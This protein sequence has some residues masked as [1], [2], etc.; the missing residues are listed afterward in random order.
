MKKITIKSYALSLVF[1]I[2]CVC[3]AQS[4]SFQFKEMIVNQKDY[5]IFTGDPKEQYA[6][7]M[8]ILKEIIRRENLYYQKYKKYTRTFKELNIKFEDIE[9]RESIGGTNEVCLNSGYCYSISG[10]K[11]GCEKLLVSR[12]SSKKFT[13][14][15]LDIIRKAKAN[16]EKDQKIEEYKNR[17]KSSIYFF[18]YSLVDNYFEAFCPAGTI[19]T[20]EFFEYYDKECNDGWCTYKLPKDFFDK[21]SGLKQTKEKRK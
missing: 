7:S 4:Q 5:D 3:S 18:Q 11:N 17:M 13:E 8:P 10:C 19:A 21:I 12:V 1:V 20:C 16:G 14:K 6:E 2:F 15:N 9:T